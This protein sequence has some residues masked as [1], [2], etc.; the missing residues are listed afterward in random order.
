MR[1]KDSDALSRLVFATRSGGLSHLVHAIREV[2]DA[3]VGLFDLSGSTLAASPSRSIWAADALLGARDGDVVEGCAVRAV[4]VDGERVACLAVRTESDDGAVLPVA[5][6]LV[7]IELMRLRAAQVGWRELVSGLLDD[8]LAGRVSEDDAVARLR[9]AGLDV[10]RPFRM[11]VG[12]ADLPAGARRS[13][14][15]G[16]IYALMN[17]QRE[18]FLRVVRDGRVLMLVPDDDLPDRIA[19]TLL[20]QLSRLGAGARVGVSLPHRGAAGVRVGFFEASSALEEGEGVHHPRR[21]D[22]VRLLVMTNAA[23]PLG[24]LAREQLRPLLDYDAAHGTALLE[25]FRVYLE[26]DR[27]IVRATE[28]LFIHRN[29]LRYRLR[30]ITG[31]LDVDL[32]SVATIA[33]L[34]LALRA[35]DGEGAFDKGNVQ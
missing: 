21:L 24:E 5:V 10:S 27:D 9:A 18:P 16:G 1:A 35:L 15:W 25:T 14:P 17:G 20:R 33:T 8:I 32:D 26:T 7:A 3:D 19:E 31:L 2:L 6:D 23:V 34:W 30:Q 11:L 28:R 13:L 22:L 29:T 4:E 12:W